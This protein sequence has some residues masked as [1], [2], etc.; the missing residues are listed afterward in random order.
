KQD[1]QRLANWIIALGHH[2]QV[3]KMNFRALQAKAKETKVDANGK[4]L[5][6]HKYCRNFQF[7]YFSCLGPKR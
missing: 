5:V 2:I 3:E 1:H 6:L 4:S 7:Y